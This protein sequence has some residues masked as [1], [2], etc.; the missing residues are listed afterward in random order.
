[1]SIFSKKIKVLF[2]IVGAASAFL[3]IS[4]Q[5]ADLAPY[6][7]PPTDSNTP[8]SEVPPDTTPSFQA[9]VNSSASLSFTPS[10]SISGSNTTLQGVSTYYTITLTFPSATGPGHY[11]I[12]SSFYPNFTAKLIN[13]ASTYVVTSR[14]GLGSIEIDSISTNGKYYGSFN[15][16]A[17]DTITNVDA[18]VNQGTFYHL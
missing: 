8:T 11:T 15:F 7:N 3:F 17:K 10:K 12:G 1:M 13:G 6:S 16:N 18:N 9:S 5:K 14:W 2:F 4:C